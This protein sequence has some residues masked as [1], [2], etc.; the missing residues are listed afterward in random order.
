MRSE[1]RLKTELREMRK[2]VE[3]VPTCIWGN[4][5]QNIGEVILSI[6]TEGEEMK[7]EV[8]K[9]VIGDE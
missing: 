3:I 1:H 2:E 9:L 8:E 5:I 7:V 6:E 4:G